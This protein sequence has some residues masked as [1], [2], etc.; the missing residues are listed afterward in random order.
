ML[1]TVYLLATRFGAPRFSADFIMSTG[2]RKSPRE[3]RIKLLRSTT[4][5]AAYQ[6][7]NRYVSDRARSFLRRRHQ[8]T[9]SRGYRQFPEQVVFGTLGVHA[10]RRV[11]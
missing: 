6:S 7:V 5:S 11:Q 9:P 3:D 4:V 1:D 8:G 2:S 10:V